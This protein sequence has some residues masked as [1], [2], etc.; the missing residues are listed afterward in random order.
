MKH[1]KAYIWIL[2]VILVICAILLIAGNYALRFALIPEIHGIVEEDERRYAEERYPGI[3]NWYDNL[4]NEGLLKDTIIVNRNGLKLHGVFAPAAVADS[5]AGT[6]IVIHGYTDSHY[7]FINLGRMYREDLNFNIFMPELHFHGKSEGDHAQMGWLDRL[8]VKEWL[9]VVNG[10]WGD[11]DIVVHGVSMGGATTMML[12]GESDLPENV[13]AF[14]E[15]CGYSSVWQQFKYILKADFGLPSFPMMNITNMLCKIKYGWSFKEASC[16]EQLKKCN[17]PMLF[18][19]GEK[20]DYVP[21]ADLYIN[22]DAKTQGYKEIWVAEG[23]AHATSYMDHPE[24]YTLTV[25][26]FLINCG[27]ST[28]NM[29]CHLK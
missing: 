3:I 6:A 25:K 13:K 9:K 28:S 14:V 4:K 12:S 27:F 29:E 21:T 26:N 7:G 17:K 11:S 8:D 15:D 10:I 22:Y 1:R 2:S 23:S 18:I 5:A 16:T 20:D 24:E 19:H